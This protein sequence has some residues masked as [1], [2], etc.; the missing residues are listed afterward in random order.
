MG[1]KNKGDVVEPEPVVVDTKALKDAKKEAKKAERVAAR[2]EKMAVSAPAFLSG[3][4]D[5]LADAELFLATVG[6][7]VGLPMLTVHFD[8]KEIC[9]SSSQFSK[10]KAAHRFLMNEPTVE[11]AH[12]E[13]MTLMMIDPDAPEREEDG[14]LPGKR[15][16]WLHWL[17]SGCKVR[18]ALYNKPPV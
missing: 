15:G 11:W 18:G 4:A 12:S 16:P 2:L 1:K 10:T 13:A 7:P 5:S 8:G 3:P 17:I 6:V 9:A 14:S